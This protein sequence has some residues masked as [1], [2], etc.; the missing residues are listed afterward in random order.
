MGGA[1]V[2][3]THDGTAPWYNPAG[4]GRV[5]A[6]IGTGRSYGFD[7]QG[8]PA[9]CDVQSEAIYFTLGS[10]TRLGEAPEKPL[11]STPEASESA[12][13]VA[14]VAPSEQHDI[15]ATPNPPPQQDQSAKPHGGL[16][17]FLGGKPMFI[18]A[19]R[20]IQRID[21]SG[22]LLLGVNDTGD[23]SGSFDVTVEV[24]P[25]DLIKQRHP[26]PAY[27]APSWGQ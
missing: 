17:A 21:Q 12:P 8:N 5:T 11:A 2:A 16:V 4:L 22:Q 15:E 18:G 26:S 6:T 25:D 27:Q 14:G 1:A 23:N 3:I 10:S 20:E 24:N 19:N 13:P 7:D 9:H